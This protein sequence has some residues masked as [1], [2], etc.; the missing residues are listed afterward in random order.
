MKSK[1]LLKLPRDAITPLLE[2]SMHL[3]DSHKDR[4]SSKVS[5]GYCRYCIA[6][7]EQRVEA[8]AAK[9]EVLEH[10][11]TDT[12]AGRD[13]SG[14]EPS[15]WVHGACRHMMVRQCLSYCHSLRDVGTKSCG[16]FKANSSRLGPKSICANEASQ[17]LYNRRQWS[18]FSKHG[19]RRIIRGLV[20]RS[21][22]SWRSGSS[23]QMAS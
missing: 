3:G 6:R 19:S 4:W 8:I 17:T 2:L 14:G 21:P 12:I 22:H 18:S 11:S 9:C 20:P 15:S 10:S 5:D 23:V 13:F 1:V 7:V 16:V